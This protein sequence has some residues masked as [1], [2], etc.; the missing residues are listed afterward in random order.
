MGKNANNLNR[1]A[2]MRR[3]RS[4]SVSCLKNALTCPATYSRSEEAEVLGSFT[5][6]IHVWEAAQRNR[7]CLNDAKL[8]NVCLLKIQPAVYSQSWQ[9]RTMTKVLPTRPIWLPRTA[10][11][12]TSVLSGVPQK[13]V[14][15]TFAG[16]STLATHCLPPFLSATSS[17][18]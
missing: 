1:K 15:R 6:N 9:M 7:S 5:L 14:E 13:Q 8:K 4:H 16:Q 17:S 11:R 3:E 12:I 2:D 10:P 18:C